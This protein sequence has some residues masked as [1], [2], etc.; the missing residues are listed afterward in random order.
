MSTQNPKKSEKKSEIDFIQSTALCYFSPKNTLVIRTCC[1]HFPI[2]LHLSVFKPPSCPQHGLCAHLSIGRLQ[3]VTFLSCILRGGT[4]PYP[5]QNVGEELA[6]TSSD[7]QKHL[8]CMEYDLAGCLVESPSYGLNLVSMPRGG[9][10]L[11]GKEPKDV[12]GKR[13]DPEEDRIGLVLPT[14]HPLHTEADL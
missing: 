6:E 10:R 2:V 9:E 4:L 7:F 12:I 1:H 3:E 14:G 13:S 11:E 8:A 5:E